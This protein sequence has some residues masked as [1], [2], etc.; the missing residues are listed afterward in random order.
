MRDMTRALVKN[1]L[2]MP[3]RLEIIVVTGINKIGRGHS[4]DN[5]MEDGRRS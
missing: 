2:H 1:F 4:P 3:N 5:V